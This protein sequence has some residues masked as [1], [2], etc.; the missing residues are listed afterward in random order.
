MVHSVILMVL[1]Q[2]LVIKGDTMKIILKLTLLLLI[3]TN[4][5]ASAPD[6]IVGS[7]SSQ[8]GQTINIPVTIDLTTGIISDQFDIKYDANLLT[9]TNVTIGTANPTWSIFFN[10]TVAGTLK[11]GMFSTAPLTGA[12]LN[13]ANITFTTKAPAVGST[14]L[15][16]PNLT[17]SNVLF[18]QA[19]ITSVTNGNFTLNILGDVNQDGQITAADASL[20]AQYVVSLSTLTTIQQSNADVSKDGTI[21]MYDAAK[22]AQFAIGIIT[23]F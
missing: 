1:G 10:K 14:L 22:I 21:T 7:A 13:I 8:A 2:V 4:V 6:L 19:I 11:I 23:T 5:F 16:T 3:S 17:A 18:D 15:P 9:P 12:N 20:V